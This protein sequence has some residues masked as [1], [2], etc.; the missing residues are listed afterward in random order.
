MRW[1]RRCRSR[2]RA[3]G[4]CT[5][6][7]ARTSRTSRRRTRSPPTTSNPST[8]SWRQGSP[9][10]SRSSRPSSGSTTTR[11]PVSPTSSGSP[12]TPPR[13]G[14]TCGSTWKAATTSRRRSSLYERLRAVQPKTGHLP[15]GVPAPHGGRHRAP[16]TA[17]S[18]RSGWSR[19]PTTR[20][21]RSP[22]R[23]RRSVDANYVGLSV[24][25]LLDGRGRPIRLGL[26][27]HDVALIEQIAEQ[28]GAAGIGRDGFEVEM[29]YGIRTDEQYRLAQVGLSCPGAHR[30][31]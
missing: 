5:R 9:A 4:R 22:T 12:T 7:S 25:F 27:T 20:R 11:L 16:P 15:A 26:G 31:R 28:V 14:R 8:R 29:L 10:R 21:S 19:A 1:P 3:S 17:R 18:R 30:L 24:R 13:T 23:D 2:R 6:A